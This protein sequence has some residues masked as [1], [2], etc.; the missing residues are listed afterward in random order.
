MCF[1]PNILFDSKSTRNE[2]ET[3]QYVQNIKTRWEQSHI[4]LESIVEHFENVNATEQ[5]Q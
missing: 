5:L 1:S 3:K 2:D 4:M